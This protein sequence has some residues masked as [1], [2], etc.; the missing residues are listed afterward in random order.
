MEHC[1]APPAPVCCICSPP[2]PHTQPSCF[3]CSA[4]Y[5]PLLPSQFLA[6][7]T[8]KDFISQLSLLLTAALS[9]DAGEKEATLQGE[10]EEPNDQPEK[11]ELDDISPGSRDG[12][13]EMGLDD[14]LEES[15]STS[16][17]V[18]GPSLPVAE[19]KEIQQEEVRHEE[20]QCEGAEVCKTAWC[21]CLQQR[22]E[23]ETC[24]NTTCS[25]L[26]HRVLGLLFLSHDFSPTNQDAGLNE[27]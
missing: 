23:D 22:S 17:P 13:F 27:L 3:F 25:V 19:E 24:M 2:T 20:V 7:G 1:G 9:E 14:S 16:L 26:T 15:T 12:Y 11:T 4:P 18:H 21:I 5:C 8:N 6:L 10:E